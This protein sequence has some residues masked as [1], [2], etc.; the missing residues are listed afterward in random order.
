MHRLIDGVVDF[1]LGIQSGGGRSLGPELQNPLPAVP[2][3]DV[4]AERFAKKL[5]PGTVLLSSQLVDLVGEVGRE[6]DGKCVRW[7]LGWPHG[8]SDKKD[9]Y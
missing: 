5:A 1:C 6:R 4:A 8:V 9:S 3:V 7:A 2:A